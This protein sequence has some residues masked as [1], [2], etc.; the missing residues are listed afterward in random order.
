MVPRRKWEADVGTLLLT[1]LQAL[2]G[3]HDFTK[4]PLMSSLC[5]RSDPGQ[6]TACS[7]LASPVCS[8]LWQFLCL[9]LFLMTLWVLRGTR[10]AVCTS[11]CD[12][13]LC[14]VFWRSDCGCALSEERSRLEVPFSS[15]RIYMTSLMTL[16]LNTWSGGVFLPS[17]LGI[18]NLPFHCSM[19]WKWVIECGPP[20][21][22][23]VDRD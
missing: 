3:F 21:G 9:S 16:T 22:G 14:A 23:G 11:S 2:F 18:H 4:S 1:E 6:R 13:G 17:A 5:S 10:R 12:L 7:C 15:R 8:G 20:S 19:V